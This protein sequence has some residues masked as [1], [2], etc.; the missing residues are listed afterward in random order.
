M[1]VDKENQMEG[2]SNLIYCLSKASR[3][4]CVIVEVGSVN[5]L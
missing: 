2:V 4:D 5:V 1:H 3:W